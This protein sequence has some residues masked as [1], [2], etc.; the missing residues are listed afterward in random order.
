MECVFVGCGS[1]TL[2]SESDKPVVREAFL[3]VAPPLLYNGHHFIVGYCQVHVIGVSAGLEGC[4][5][6]IFIDDVY[7]VAY[8]EFFQ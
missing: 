1:T 2:D 7:S 3:L 6:A 8:D 4:D 5:L